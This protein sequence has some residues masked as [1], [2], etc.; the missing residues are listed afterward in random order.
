MVL[1]E[2]SK[3]VFWAIFIRIH[4]PEAG[5]ETLDGGVWRWKKIAAN[6]HCALWNNLEWSLWDPSTIHMEAGTCHRVLW[7]SYE[8]GKNNASRARRLWNRSWSWTWWRRMTP[9][10]LGLTYIAITDA[11]TSVKM[12]RVCMCWF[13]VDGPGFDI[14]YKRWRALR[15]DHSFTE[16]IHELTTW[17]SPWSDQV[18][19]AVW[20]D[21]EDLHSTSWH[22]SYNVSFTFSAS[23]SY[24]SFSFSAW[25]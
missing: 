14:G 1:A 4:A 20:R 21:K 15:I 25:V 12:S 22:K 3:F 6:S 8:F 10:G 16:K 18:R 17:L 13:V 2:P 5:E 19:F 7:M 24:R 23:W 9:S 11:F